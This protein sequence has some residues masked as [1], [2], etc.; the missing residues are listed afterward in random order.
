[1][2]TRDLQATII[3]GIDSLLEA[4]LVRRMLSAERKRLLRAQRQYWLLAPDTQL[5][6]LLSLY[7]AE[8]TRAEDD[9]CETSTL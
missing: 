2:T 7:E 3:G 5:L 8:P 9:T 6:H 1:M 4:P